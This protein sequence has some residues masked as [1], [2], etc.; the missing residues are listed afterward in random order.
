MCQESSVKSLE[1]RIGATL[2][3]LLVGWK[4]RDYSSTTKNFPGPS[5]PLTGREGGGGML[6]RPS[7]CYY[8]G[9]LVAPQPGSAGYI[10]TPVVH[11]SS[12]HQRHSSTPQ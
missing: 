11:E 4:E 10:K 12:R 2:K 8:V 6:R 5:N 9:R 7:R 1:S 3:P